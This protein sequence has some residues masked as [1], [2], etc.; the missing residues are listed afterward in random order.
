MARLTQWERW[1]ALDDALGSVNAAI[2]V[3]RESEEDDDISDMLDD[4]SLALHYRRKQVYDK[5]EACDNAE[6]EQE[7]RDACVGVI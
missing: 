3:M 6:R 7:R 5:I 4:V 2:E 1:Q